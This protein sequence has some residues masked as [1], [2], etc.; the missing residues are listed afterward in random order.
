MGAAM[1]TKLYLVEQV[2]WF[3]S[4]GI[5]YFV[6]VD[7]ISMAMVILTSIIIF[8]GVLASWYVEGRAKEFFALL[9]TLVTG[10]F[11]V[12]VSFDLFLFFMFYE[13]AVLPMY[14]L[15][16]IWGTGPKEYSAMKLT[17]MLLVGLGVHSGRYSGALSSLR[18]AHVQPA[19]AGD[20]TFPA[21]VPAVGLPDDLRGLWR[22]WALC[23]RCTPGRRTAT[24]R[25]RRPSRCCTRAC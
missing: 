7:G 3:R 4:L 17:L 9:L 5:E 16:G 25:R 19:R 23:I 8:T 21:R 6:G 11:G 12:F 22:A 2:P 13:L 24:P 1:L 20:A 14:L 18:A 10:V 15:I